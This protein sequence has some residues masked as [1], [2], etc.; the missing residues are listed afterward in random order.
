MK[1]IG[2]LFFMMLLLSNIE[3][4][5]GDY[6]IDTFLDY[7]QEKG[8]YEL[9][10]EIKNAFGDDVAIAV[11]KELVQSNDCEIVVRVY[12]ETHNSFDWN[13]PSLDEKILNFIENKCKC[14]ITDEKMKYLILFIFSYF[15]ELKD[16]NEMNEKEIIDKI[17]IDKG[18]IDKEIIDL[19]CRIIKNTIIRRYLLL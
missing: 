13:E 9:I 5:G 18:I 2:Y 17:I 15:Y 14:K 16:I 8:Y 10:Q 6:S 3:V 19:I 11:C 7:L 1:T 12:M 4:Q